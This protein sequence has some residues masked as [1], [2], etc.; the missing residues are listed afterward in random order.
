MN[1]QKSGKAKGKKQPKAQQAPKMQTKKKVYS[2]DW[3]ARKQRADERRARQNDA[4]AAKKKLAKEARIRAEQQ[5]KKEQEERYRSYHSKLEAA[6]AELFY[7]TRDRKRAPKWALDFIKRHEER[8]ARKASRQDHKLNVAIKKE[9]DAQEEREV[10]QRLQ[11]AR[12]YVPRNTTPVKTRAQREAQ[13]AVCSKKTR[14]QNLAEKQARIEAKQNRPIFKNLKP[15]T[16]EQKK[17]L[18]DWFPIQQAKE[19]RLAEKVE[20]AYD[21]NIEILKKVAWIN[22]EYE[23]ERFYDLC[24]RYEHTFRGATYEQY[25]N[26][27]PAR[28]HA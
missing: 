13:Q 20:R 2:R 27:K 25:K 22:A 8:E 26:A 7:A 19:I 14:E 21:H 28:L 18:R 3:A 4:K 11:K 15:I 17:A 24:S 9:L 6:K 23:R 5:A 1:K 12:R 16:A 10:Q